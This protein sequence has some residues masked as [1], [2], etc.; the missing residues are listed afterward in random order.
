M[1]MNAYAFDMMDTLLFIERLQRCR[2]IELF[3]A[4]LRRSEG[5][6]V[7]SLMSV[8][9]SELTEGDELIPNSFPSIT[10]RPSPASPFEVHQKA[11]RLCDSCCASP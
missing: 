8:Q 11:H 10:R 6:T 1:L 3:A 9:L 4:P 7:F 5:A 2:R